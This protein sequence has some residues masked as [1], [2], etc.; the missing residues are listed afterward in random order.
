MYKVKKLTL[1]NTYLTEVLQ[2]VAQPPTELYIQG[3]LEEFLASPRVALVGS[4]KVTPYGRAVTIK[5]ARE[6]AERGVVIVSGLALGTDSIAHAAALEVG[7]KTIAVLPSSLTDIYPRT[8]HSLARQILQTNNVLVSEY[9]QD[10]T[11]HKHQFIARNRLIAGLSQAVLIP[12]A[13]EKSGSLH[14]ASF[15]LEEGKMVLAVPGNITSEF[16][17]GTNNLI[18]AVATPVT[19]VSDVLEALGLSVQPQTAPAGRSDEETIILQLLYA[20][21]SDAS[22][23]QLQ[24]NIEAALF[25]QTLTMLEI[26]GR[27]RPIG[28]GHWSLA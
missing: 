5:I 21:T 24:S 27:I 16:S 6:L 13:A 23:L 9:S 14:T 4:R 3:P 18:K 17:R 22:E 1:N 20:G 8:H 12:E 26:T 2:G 7:G 19:S 15:A 28:A 25:N 11:P 10:G